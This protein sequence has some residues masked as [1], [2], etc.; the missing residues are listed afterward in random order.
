MP[1]YL[2][3]K[4]KR[5]L[6]ALLIFLIILL[7]FAF[8][9]LM[10]KPAP[11][12]PVIDPVVIEEPEPTEKEKEV[13]QAVEERTGEVSITNLSKTFAERYGS[14]SNES[15]FANIKDVLVLMTDAFVE[16]TEAF[17]QEARAGSEYYGVTTRVISME[18]VEQND[19]EGF[20]TIQVTTQREEASGSP[21]NSSIFYQDLIIELVHVEGEWKISNASWQ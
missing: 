5:N 12:P 21:Q 15:D 1:L 10:R 11:E 14:Y 18:V 9:F 17:M 4:A 3:H 8:V 20:A 16:Q 7:I 2:S 6:I 13:M 19:E